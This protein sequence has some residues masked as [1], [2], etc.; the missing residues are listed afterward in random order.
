MSEN[1]EIHSCFTCGYT[2]KHGKHGG[3]NCADLMGKKIYELSERNRE[4]ERLSMA[5]V[6]AV[7]NEDDLPITQYALKCG[8]LVNEIR[9]YINK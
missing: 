1:P 5:L 4:L 3:H 2:W 6:D 7:E 8:R 9:A